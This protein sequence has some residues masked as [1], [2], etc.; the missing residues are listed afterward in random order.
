MITY[1]FGLLK[2]ILDTCECSLFELMD[3]FLIV[4]DCLFVR[5]IGCSFNFFEY[6]SRTVLLLYTNM[7]CVLVHNNC[8]KLR[9]GQAV[10]AFC[11]YG[12]FCNF[13][14]CLLLK[15]RS[16]SGLPEIHACESYMEIVKIRDFAVVPCDSFLASHDLGK[17]LSAG[18]TKE[19][20]A[21][22]LH[23]RQFVDRLIII[24]LESTY[25]RSVIAKGMCSFCPELMLK[26]D[27]VA[28]FSQFADLCRIL[29][30]CGALSVDESS[31]A[32]EEHASFIVEKR[33]YHSSS[34][35]SAGDIV[36][37]VPYLLRV[38]GFLSRHHLLRVFKP[39]CLVSEVSASQYHAVS[40]DLSGIALSI[41]YFQSCVQLVQ[42]YILSEGCSHQSFFSDQTL[43]VVKKAI[44]D[45]GRFFGASNFS[46]WTD[47][48]GEDVDAFV[49]KYSPLFTTFLAERRKSFDARYVEYNNAN[50]MSRLSDSGDTAGSSGSLSS[51]IQ[52]RRQDTGPPSGI[53]VKSGGSKS[54]DC[55]TKSGSKPATVSSEGKQQENVGG[56]SGARTEACAYQSLWVVLTS[57]S[58][59]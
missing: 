13:V 29:V 1:W 34:G 45:A 36:N 40:L 42:S 53:S 33:G 15:T 32:L 39:C 20:V 43:K 47:F 38:V 9:H 31:A 52:R 55:G 54:S 19:Y 2:V 14:Y 4:V 3:C 48:C 28:V 26:G 16:T 44:A 8:P 49:V 22:R 59:R 30:S 17:Q 24:L 18:K 35:Q 5:I 56:N 50:R 6:W 46:M 41:E 23:C 25:A 58:G 7:V 21:F 57:G 10:Y 12:E 37:V 27:D 51:V 11:A